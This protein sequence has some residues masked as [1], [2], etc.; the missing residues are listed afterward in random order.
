MTQ[1]KSPQIDEVDGGRFIEAPYLN[2]KVIRGTNTREDVEMPTNSV[3]NNTLNVLQ[4]GD[5]DDNI[6][7]GTDGSGNTDAGVPDTGGNGGASPDDDNAD[8]D[9][10][11]NADTDGNSNGGNDGNGNG[12][13]DGLLPD[14]DTPEGDDNRIKAFLLKNKN[15][16]LVII[17]AVLATLCV[18]VWAKSVVKNDEVS[19]RPVKVDV[20]DTTTDTT[21]TD[22]DRQGESSDDVEV[23]ADVCDTDT[24][25]IAPDEV[26]ALK[27][28]V[29]R[30]GNHE[31]FYRNFVDRPAQMVAADTTAVVKA[32][33]S[34]DNEQWRDFIFSHLGAAY[35]SLIDPSILRPTLLGVGSDNSEAHLREYAENASLSKLV[36]KETCRVVSA[37]VYEMVSVAD[38]VDV[39]YIAAFGQKMEDIVF[40][41][42]P[43]RDLLPMNLI[44][45]TINLD[46]TQPDA[47]PTSF[48]IYPD[49]NRPALVW[50]SDPIG[51]VEKLSLTGENTDPTGAP[52]DNGA[53]KPEANKPEADKPADKPEGNKPAVKPA[54]KPAVK[55]A[56]KPAVKPASKPVDQPV[57]KPEANKPEAD[58][59]ADKPVDEP[60]DK[61]VDEPVDKPVDEPVDK[62]VDEPK[63]DQQSQPPPPEGIGGNNAAQATNG[64]TVPADNPEGTPKV[65]ARPAT[66]LAPMEMV[67]VV[68]TA[69][70]VRPATALAP[71]EM[72]TVVVT[73][74]VVRPATALAPMEMVTVVVTATVVR[75]ATALAPM[76]MVT[77]V[78]TA[79]VV[80][81]ATALAPM[82]MVTVVVTATVVRPATALAPMEM[83]TVVVT[84]TATATVVRPATALAPMEMVTVEKIPRPLA[85]QGGCITRNR[86]SARSHLPLSCRHSNRRSVDNRQPHGN[87]CLLFVDPVC[88]FWDRRGTTH[89][90]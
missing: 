59:P 27:D 53:N 77:V 23:V 76:E 84:A 11:G 45:G 49:K 1:A 58:K 57:D 15:M 41:E 75:P 62:P 6:V 90:F 7:P 16:L 31:E 81:P 29:P 55:P 88:P 30:V 8:T 86:G 18:V 44:R 3:F 33:Y 32:I 67:T 39:I 60:V 4:K 38:S 19:K 82:E 80:R 74:T 71:M 70:V 9:G 56:S 61:P 54:S 35:M 17:V 26:E 24:V 13:N 28:T 10:N 22:T 68:V 66:A 2:T 64:E 14:G 34:N 5:S 21:T 87:C 50:L 85:Q 47:M 46:E 25:V 20:N 72:V 51:H 43:V 65:I 52:S 73:A 40:V 12:G 89:L 42:V 78:V 79:T 83:V 37:S 63:P 48:L 36:V 69:T